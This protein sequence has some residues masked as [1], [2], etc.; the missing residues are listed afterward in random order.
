MESS[1]IFVKGLPPTFDEA[2]FRKHFGQKGQVTD[3][4]IFPNRRIGYV[5]FKTSEDAEKAAKY[6]N[7]T[8]IRMS[9]IGVEIAR[10]IDESPASRR[11]PRAKVT[12]ANEQPLAENNRLKRKRDSDSKKKEDAVKE[13]PKLKEFLDSYKSKSDKKAMEA[14]AMAQTTAVAEDDA[15]AVVVEAGASDDEYEQVPKKTKRSTSSSKTVHEAPMPDASVEVVVAELS[16]KTEQ[17]ADGGY[18]TAITDDEW[19]RSRTS[20]LLGLLDEDEDETAPAKR[21]DSD[22]ET[23]IAE[24]TTRHETRQATPSKEPASSMPTPPAEEEEEDEIV[25]KDIEAVRSTMRLFVR[26]LPYDVKYEDLEAEFSPFGNLE[27][28]SSSLCLLPRYLMIS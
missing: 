13:D 2:Q 17:Q 7:K 20:R 4:K 21:D 12:G 23:E 24:P 11:N 3:A 6:F 28:V 25:D 18:K 19:A 9:R 14:G 16:E 10:P 22:S 27:Q 1:R 15:A 8:F 5:G 26:N